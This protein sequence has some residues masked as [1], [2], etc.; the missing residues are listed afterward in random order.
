MSYGRL[1]RGGRVSNAVERL[2]VADPFTFDK[3]KPSAR[4]QLLQKRPIASC[5][6]LP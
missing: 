5:N 4:L 2:H 1:D 3:A 6:R